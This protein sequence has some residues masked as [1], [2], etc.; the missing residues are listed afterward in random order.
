MQYF[1]GYNK[2]SY[3]YP[4]G[5]LDM[6]E[7]V[8]P[9]VNDLQTIISM[10]ASVELLEY[11]YIMSQYY[12]I[13]ACIGSSIWPETIKQRFR[14]GTMWHRLCKML[15]L[16]YEITWPWSSQIVLNHVTTTLPI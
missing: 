2:H 5:K 11:V 4:C 7:Y 1:Y 9:Y 6:Y 3:V 14:M 16:I 12:V 15:E 8:L 13:P 10:S